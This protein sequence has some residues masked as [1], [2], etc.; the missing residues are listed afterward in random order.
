MAQASL[1]RYGCGNERTDSVFDGEV[2]A[3]MF[4]DETEDE[5]DE[6]AA[7]VQSRIADRLLQ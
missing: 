5:P 1:G 2:L 7:I 3:H 4:G 6:P